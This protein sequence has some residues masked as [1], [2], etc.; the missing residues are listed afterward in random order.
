[1]HNDQV[2][3][4]EYQPPRPLLPV[5]LGLII[6]IAFQEYLRLGLTPLLCGT[7][8]LF[9]LFVLLFVFK[10][11]TTLRYLVIFALCIL[12]GALRLNTYYETPTSHI[13]HLIGEFIPVRLTGTIINEPQI[14]QTD[15]ESEEEDETALRQPRQPGGSFIIK[16]NQLSWRGV[17]E[18]VSGVVKVNCRYFVPS[19]AY[20]DEVELLGLLYTPYTPTNPGQFNYARYLARQNI[21]KLFKVSKLEDIK[22]IAKN[23]GCPFIQVTYRVRNYLGQFIDERFRSGQANLLKALLLGRRESLPDDLEDKFI[24]SGT[25]HALSVSGLHVGVI[26]FVVFWC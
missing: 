17:S 2:I 18:T 10:K 15:E 26:V 4:D 7:I 25:I 6:G 11:A 19:V 12:A 22:A 13:K 5:V 20:G 14:Y 24:Q 3:T 1:M 9:G 21:Y 23:R 16:V 8:I